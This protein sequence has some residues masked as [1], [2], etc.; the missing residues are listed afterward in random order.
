MKKGFILLT[1][2]LALFSCDQKSKVEKAVEEMPLEV[3]VVRF[4]KA[5]FE[6]KPENLEALKQK[7]PVF[8]PK[9]ND[10]SVWIEKLQHPQWRELYAE[11]EKKFPDFA[12]EKENIETLYKHIKYYFPETKIPKIYTVISEMDYQ[13]K[14]INADSLLVISLELYL[15]KNHKFYQ[16]PEYIKQNFEPTQMMPDIVSAFGVRKIAPPTENTLLSQ[17]IYAGKDL[18]LKDIL[19]PEFSDADKMGYTPEQITW[20]QENESYMWRF[21]IENSLLYDT[22]QKLIPRFI[23]PAPFSKFYLEIDNETPG[24]V[25]AW[26]GWQIVRSYMKNNETSVQQLLQMDAKTIFEKSKYKP[27]KNG[28]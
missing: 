28:E 16:F 5:F 7:H 18:Y 9:G 24:R 23:N 4:D 21:F 22:D 3:E 14:V 6:T 17:M 10:D 8:F 12:Q 15:G 1:L 26:L 2:I 27:K 13:T 20:S 11:V 19:L 25:G